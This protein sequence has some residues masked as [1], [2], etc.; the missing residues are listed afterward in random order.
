MNKN[1]YSKYTTSNIHIAINYI[2]EFR[3]KLFNYNPIEDSYNKEAEN[4]WY[5]ATT[6]YKKHLPELGKRCENLNIFLKDF[7]KKSHYYR[8]HKL[9]KIMENV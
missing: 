7:T 9:K 5:S 2:T 3:D 6:E 1:N 8:L 4:Y